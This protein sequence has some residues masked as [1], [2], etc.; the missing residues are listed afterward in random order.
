MR[1]YKNQLKINFDFS[2]AS[3]NLDGLWVSIGPAL[4]I[5]HLH[6]LKWRYTPNHPQ[7]D[8]LSIESRGFAMFWGSSTLRTPQLVSK[9]I[10]QPCFRPVVLSHVSAL[11][12]IPTLPTLEMIGFRIPTSCV[13][14]F[15]LGYLWVRCLPDNDHSDHS[16]SGPNGAS[17]WQWLLSPHGIPRKVYTKSE[18][19]KNAVLRSWPRTINTSSSSSSSGTRRP[20]RSPRNW[21]RVF[22]L[23]LRPGFHIKKVW[24]FGKRKRGVLVHPRLRSP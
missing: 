9:P 2:P 7:K 16:L 17:S 23:D 19:V 24:G 12:W 20:G 1:K 21:G 3:K 22:R 13:F 6:H 10:Q 15:L 5:G 8:H 14:L 11:P 4:W 18:S